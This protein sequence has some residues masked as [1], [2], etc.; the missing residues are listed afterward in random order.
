VNAAITTNC[1]GGAADGLVHDDGTFENGRGNI[2]TPLV[3]S[4]GLPGP[5]FRVQQVCVCFTSGDGGSHT[6]DIVFL[7]DGVTP[8]AELARYGTFT[9]TSVPIFPVSPGTTCR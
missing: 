3:E 6:Y 4:F 9:A 5:A 8:G 1:T 7:A 2:V